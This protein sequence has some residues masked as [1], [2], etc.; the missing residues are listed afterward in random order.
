MGTMGTSSVWAAECHSVARRGHLK[1]WKRSASQ[2]A[3]SVLLFHTQEHHSCCYITD[4]FSVSRPTRLIHKAACTFLSLYLSLS[5]P[6]ASP[7]LAASPTPEA[8]YRN[9]SSSDGAVQFLSKT[10]PLSPRL[11]FPQLRINNWWL[12][13][14]RAS[15]SLPQRALESAIIIIFIIIM[16]LR[17]WAL[18]FPPLVEAAGGRKKC[19]TELMWC[20]KL[21]GQRGWCAPWGSRGALRQVRGCERSGSGGAGLTSAQSACISRACMCK[22][23]GQSAECV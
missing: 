15:S 3:A 8:G 11:S 23:F 18:S 1:S 19:G 9:L 17:A 2:P 4:L 12:C 20:G 22:L 7:F 6:S 16:A 21:H 5:I 10:A 14:W 13:D